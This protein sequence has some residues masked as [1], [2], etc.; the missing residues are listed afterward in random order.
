MSVAS[1]YSRNWRRRGW[2]SNRPTKWQWHKT[3]TSLWME[4]NWNVC[5]S[6]LSNT[7][8]T[9]FWGSMQ[10]TKLPNQKNRGPYVEK[11]CALSW[12]LFLPKVLFSLHHSCHMKLI[13]ISFN[14]GVHTI[15]VADSKEVTVP[16][17][18]SPCTYS[19]I[20]NPFCC[21][22]I[23]WPYAISVLE[24]VYSSETSFFIGFTTW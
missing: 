8:K 1:S 10:K 23:G 12:N 5:K 16:S 19:E 2:L 14:F 11:H 18:F 21:P 13:L 6:I 3:H 15:W 4:H 22:I 17:S 9:F 20:A 7:F 24:T